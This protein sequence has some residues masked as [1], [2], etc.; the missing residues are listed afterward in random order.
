MPKVLVIGLDGAGYHLLGDWI[1]DGT[2]SSL[3]NLTSRGVSHSL[4]SSHP[5]VTSP[6]WRCYSTGVNPGKHGVFWWERID[7]DERRITIP[8][9]RSYDAKDVW[10]Y[11]GDAGHTNAVI[12]MPTTHPPAPLS[13]WMI[14]D[15]QGVDD[16]TFPPEL[17][18][19]LEGEIG[20]RTTLDHPIS[21]IARDPEMVDA[22]TE[23]IDCRFDAANYLIDEYD[24]DFLHLTLF[25]TNAIQHYVWGGERIKAVWDHVDR[26]IGELVSESDNVIVMSDHGSHRIETVFN[27]NRWLESE[28]YQA[29][30]NSVGDQL[31]GLG[32][33][34]ESIRDLVDRVGL[35]NATRQIV[36]AWVIRSIPHAGGGV[37]RDAKQS[38]IDWEETVALASGQGPIYL[39]GDDRSALREEL[40]PK[41][42]R[43]RSPN[44][45]PIARNV[46]RAEE[47][48]DGPYVDDGPDI[49]I[50]QADGVHIPDVIGADDTFVDADEWTWRSENHRDGIFIAAGS[51][52]DVDGAL[53]RQPTLY[54]L[55]PTILHWYGVPVPNE[56]DGD[57][58]TELFEPESDPARRSIERADI[59]IHDARE[60][61]AHE[62]DDSVAERLEDLGYFSD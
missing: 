57:V 30:A 26:R 21:R 42:E 59:D 11:L 25:V 16:Y 56:F 19:E 17:A 20:Y 23:L 61:T 8:D 3:S 49:V 7:R 41:L 50:E 5:P 47:I 48:Y 12:N 28:G 22:V 34:K 13:G 40:I 31:T 55:A 52:V 58:L 9:S 62:Y 53:S 1:R 15:G 36:P 46:Y 2:L 33:N 37:G 39:F 32:V 38:K 43:L 18:A 29:T 24:P 54:D 10:T 60:P 6:A 4:R 27:I 51:D 35:T 45:K 14:S 44:G